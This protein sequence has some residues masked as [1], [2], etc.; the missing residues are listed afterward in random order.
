MIIGRCA[1]GMVE[2]GQSVILDSSS[3]VLE[4]AHALTERDLSL[5]V[6]TNDLRIAIALREWPK[7]QLRSQTACCYCWIHRNSNNPLFAKSARS[8][9]SMRSSATMVSIPATGWR[10]SS[11]ASALPS[12]RST[13]RYERRLALNGRTRAGYRN[14]R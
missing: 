5:T 7:V 13:I 9:A 11:S 4:V 3:T 8:S 6:V 10:S 2:D 1:A 14:P 12:S